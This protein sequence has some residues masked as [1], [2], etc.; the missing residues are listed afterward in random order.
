MIGFRSSGGP[1]GQL[2]CEDQARRVAL[3]FVV[4]EAGVLVE[5]RTTPRA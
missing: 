5:P 1:T 3:M 2:L 4:A